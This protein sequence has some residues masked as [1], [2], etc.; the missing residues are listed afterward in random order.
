VETYLRGVLAQ[1]LDT[2]RVVGRMREAGW[3][4][5]IADAR[6]PRGARADR[7]N[8]ARVAVFIVEPDA[9]EDADRAVSRSVQK[10]SAGTGTRAHASESPGHSGTNGGGPTNTGPDALRD[11]SALRDTRFVDVLGSENAVVDAIAAAFDA[12]EK[13]A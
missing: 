3:R 6:M 11:T 9:D 2:A 4:H 1:R 13:A 5:K 10:G 12:T 7:E 8:R